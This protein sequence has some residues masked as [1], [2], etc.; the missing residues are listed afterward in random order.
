M[1]RARRLPDRAAVL[2]HLLAITAGLACPAARRSAPSG[3]ET[4]SP[5]HPPHA[6]RVPCDRYG[7]RSNANVSAARN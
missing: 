6:L 4:S 2:L 1:R 7:K 3:W 5:C